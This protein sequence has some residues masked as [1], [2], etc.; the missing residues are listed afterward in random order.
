M[1]MI[2]AGSLV[3][4]TG[5]IGVLHMP[6]AA[7]MLRRIVPGGICP[8]MRGT[9]AE[10]DRAHAIGATAIRATA[11]APAP[12][13]PALV[14]ALDQSTKLN[15]AAWAASHDVSCKSIAGNANLQRC[16][17]VP[18]SA[19]S[20]PEELGP[21]EEMTLEFKSSGQLVNVQTMRR[22]LSGAQAAL[23]AGELEHAAAA[24]LGAPSTHAGE[25]TAAHL[26]R[27]LLATYVASHVFTDYR[28]TVSATNLA[29]TGIMV[30]EEYL[31]LR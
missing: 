12:A 21:L 31:S 6:F 17:N 24:A 4:L 18:A 8:I 15:L 5:L 19:V 10:I 20:E 2:A 23:A 16:T 29:P 13:R 22:R 14:F 7:P 1:A 26:S 25:P 27:N 28:A 30:R 9:P 3:G 11:S